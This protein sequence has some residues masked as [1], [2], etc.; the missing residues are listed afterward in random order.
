MLNLKNLASRI[1][2][3]TVFVAVLIG[4]ILYDQ[5]SF[6]LVFSLITILTSYEFYGLLNK[7]KI[8]QANCS[9]VLNTLGSLLLFFS[10]YVT[11]SGNYNDFPAFVI[12]IGYFLVLF[13]S[14]LFLKKKNPLH[15]LAYSALGQLY[16]ALPFCLLS[17]LAFSYNS[18][19]EYH[20]AL[21]FAL[22][23]FIWVNDSFA[24]LTGSIL[25]KH[26]MFERVS[27]KKSWE[28]FIGGAVFTIAV[29]VLYAQYH[30]LLSLFAW[31][32]FAIILIVFGTLGDLIESLFKR[33][34]GVKDSGKLLPGH[35]GIL[36][37]LDSVIFA[38]PA[39]FVYIEIL[40]YFEFI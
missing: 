29:A 5:Y 8:T 35:G 17:F 4:G 34:L 1:V 12:Y 9:V 39:Q 19:N 40:I 15:S 16:V 2:T 23:L 10:G 37:R 30:P 38:I 22:F 36:D 20:Y 31:V 13:A 18:G 3:G 7:T 27:P 33:T 25:G 24:Y 6:L 14:E 32:G 11:F 28:G 21:V 26:R